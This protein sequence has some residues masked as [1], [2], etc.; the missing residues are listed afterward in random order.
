MADKYRIS[1][2]TQ[3]MCAT[4]AM[5]KM[6]HQ[7]NFSSDNQQKASTTGAT[8]AERG[9]AVSLSLSNQYPE[10]HAMLTSK[11]AVLASVSRQMALV[12]FTPIE[13]P[14]SLPSW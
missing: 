12:G 8:L 9:A 2:Y 7:L 4:D 10:M 5:D 11:E 13:K 1:I 14:F 3:G 6:L